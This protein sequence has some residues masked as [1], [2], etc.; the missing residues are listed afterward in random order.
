MDVR[1]SSFDPISSNSN[2]GLPAYEDDGGQ[3]SADA[4][5]HTHNIIDNIVNFLTQHR[6]GKYTSSNPECFHVPQKSYE[7]LQQY[8]H[9][10]RDLG[11]YAD[12][13][14]RYSLTPQ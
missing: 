1:R 10:H 4:T 5:V 2:T 14:V 7:D 12:D 11:G 13:K 8:L 9:E 6:D 3:S